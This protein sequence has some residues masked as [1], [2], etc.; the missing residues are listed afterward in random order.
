MDSL[1]KTKDKISD[2]LKDSYLSRA[3]NLDKSTSLATEALELSR[4]IENKELIGKSLNM[5]SLLNMIQG[6]YHE[7]IKMAE[8][9]I[10]YFKEL[11]NEQGI[12][13]AKYNIA[14]INYKT[15]NYHLGLINLIDCLAIYKKH[16][17]YHNQARTL[18]SLGTIYEYFLDTKNAT[19][20]YLESIEMAK[21]AGDKN[22]ESNAYNPLS[23]MYLD[24]GDIEKAKELIDLSIKMKEE[25]GDVRGLAFAFY[26]RA[27]VYAKEGEIELAIK[28]YEESIRIH[29]EMHERLGVGMAYNKL[30]YLY[31]NI[32]DYDKAKEYIN[33]GI[34]SSEKFNVVMVQFKCYYNMYLITKAEN[35]IAEAL[36]YLEKYISTRERVINTQTSKIIENYDLIKQMELLERETK[37]Q[38]ERAEIIEKTNKAEHS[39]KAKQEFL[40]TMSH[41]IRTPL[42]A[43]I[44]IANLLEDTS[45]PEQVELISA[46]GFASNNLLQIVNDI[47]DFSKLEA[48]KMTLAPKNT[49]IQELFASIRDTYVNLA[50]D[51]GIN[52]LLKIGNTVNPS[53]LIDDAK[54]TQ[55]MNNLV[56]NAI[57]YSEKGF[58]TISIDKIDEVAEID[59]LRFSVK[60]TGLG[61]AEKYFNDI[62]E[63]FNQPKSI[64]TKTQGG[65]GLGLA[66]VKKLVELMQSK[67]EFTSELN[68]GSEFFFTL[69][70]KPLE[71]KSDRITLPQNKLVGKSILIVDDNMVNA[72]VASKLLM[73]WGLKTEHAE[74]GKDAIIKTNKNK[75]DFI[76]MD[77]HMPLMDGY[78]SCSR[79]RKSNGLNKYTPIYALTADVTAAEHADFDLNFNGILTKPINVLKLYECLTKLII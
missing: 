53:Y 29:N 13:D 3:S 48:N 75:Y 47:L 70:L 2:L 32:K 76:L 21:L 55:V 77:I 10:Q 66:I 52:L 42:N 60:D 51:K 27:K 20:S 17:D 78:E 18:K 74:N 61:I 69:A 56:S 43:V 58:V 4:K 28:Y 63:S 23:G 26:G 68:V 59:H 65:T 24:D 36:N 1:K 9:A 31:F 12:A 79:I 5:L 46:L 16:E 25:S 54:L 50:A 8:E 64:T 14:S 34:E 30:G 35:N 40:S 19:K 62:F 49:N 45:T 72:L 39:A 44:S 67:I 73:K 71:K 57:K 11:K 7:S 6:E 22:L 33:L 38:K 15:D 41:E 37:V